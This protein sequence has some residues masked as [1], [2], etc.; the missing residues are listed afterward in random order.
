MADTTTT[1]HHVE[2]DEE[3]TVAYGQMLADFS[4]ERELTVLQMLALSKSWQ[5]YIAEQC[6]VRV[7][8]CRKLP[9]EEAEIPDDTTLQ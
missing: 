4:G 5:E 8:G 2:V 3:V 9:A 1:R 6:G 7:V